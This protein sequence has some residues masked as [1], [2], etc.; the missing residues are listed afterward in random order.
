MACGTASD[1]TVSPASM[2]SAEEWPDRSRGLRTT[3]S[4]VRLAKNH[5]SAQAR[6]LAEV[7]APSV[8]IVSRET[9]KLGYFWR[10]AY[11]TPKSGPYTGNVVNP[12]TG[13]P[14]L[15]GDDQLRRTDFRK[16]KH[17]KWFCRSPS[18]DG[19]HSSAR[20]GKR[21]TRRSTGWPRWSLSAVI[22]TISSTMASRTRSELK[23]A[24][25]AQ[26]NAL[27]TL[28][29]VCGRTVI[30]AGTLL[31]GYADEVFLNPVRAGRAHDARGRLRI[32]GEAGVRQFAE[33]YGVLEKVTTIEPSCMLE[34]TGHH[35]NQ[36]AARSLAAVVRQVPDEHGGV[37]IARGH[38]RGVAAV[39][40]RGHR[41]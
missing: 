22:W 23:G 3:L 30:L 38:L 24:D 1:R 9:A 7:R 41:G 37:R 17:S 16:V 39:R 10:H 26:G 21:T 11:S 27:G 29:S 13:R 32:Y 25:T 4:D 36:T 33:T 31:G 18:V 6:W 28:A 2:R 8:W 14:I 35:H 12:D 19:R 20:S 5:R 34:G 40:G 15:A